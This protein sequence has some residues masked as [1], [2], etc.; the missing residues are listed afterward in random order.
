MWINT[1]QTKLPGLSWQYNGRRIKIYYFTITAKS[2]LQG[3]FNSINARSTLHIATR[4]RYLRDTVRYLNV[5]D[6]ETMR[7]ITF[8][9]VA[10][11]RIMIVSAFFLTN[12]HNLIIIGQ[13]FSF[14]THDGGKLAWV[15]ASCPFVTINYGAR[16]NKINIFHNLIHWLIPTFFWYYSLWHH[17]TRGAPRRWR[18]LMASK[19]LQ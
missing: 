10:A 15:T 6:Y 5:N 1:V 3:W 16:K 7:Q 19:D 9:Q 18:H 4:S 8:K 17:R 14:L 12:L 11:D 13:N 2:W